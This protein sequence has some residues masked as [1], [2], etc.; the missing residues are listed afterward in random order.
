MHRR[1]KRT[2]TQPNDG[3]PIRLLHTHKTTL[4]LLAA[5]LIVACIGLGVGEPVY[6]Q[7][8]VI[9]VISEHGGYCRFRTRYPDWV[10]RYLSDDWKEAVDDL[11][12]IEFSPKRQYL[13]GTGSWTHLRRVDD[14]TLKWVARMTRLER[15][16][17]P[18]ESI[19]DSGVRHL[20][21]L[22]CLKDLD[23]SDTKVS[24]ASVPI[25]I[26][27]RNLKY[28]DLRGTMVSDKGI[29]KIRTALPECTVYDF[30][31][32]TVQEEPRP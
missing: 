10:R 27:L 30:G 12:F 3:Q 29:E 26:G 18:C 13:I 20:S 24:D 21:A 32:Q 23:L 8:V 5:L 16:D 4:M 9:R 2:P 14:A 28:L 31:R 25:L 6:R 22:R 19:S 15:L 7:R 11:W 17:V 1:P